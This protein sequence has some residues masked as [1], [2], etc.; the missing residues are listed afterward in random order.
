MPPALPATFLA[1]IGRG[2]GDLREGLASNE[3][4]VFMGWQDIRQRY[5]RTVLG[6]WWLAISTGLLVLVLGLL[7]S[8]IFQVEVRTFLPFFAVGYV[9]WTFLPAPST[10]RARASRSSRGSSSSGGFRSRRCSTGSACATRSASRTMRSSSPRSSSGRAPPG[11]AAYLLAVPGL[12]VFAVTVF[13]ALIPVAIFCTRFRDFPQ[14]V[15]NVLQVLFFATPIMWRPDVL[16]KYP[17]DRR[18]QPGRPSARHRQAAVAR[19][20]AGTGSRGSGRW[21][22]WSLRSSPPR[23]CWAGT[24]IASPTGSSGND[25][26]MTSIVAERVRVEYPILQSTNRS[27]KRRF[28][29]AA[30]GAASPAT[31]AITS[32]SPRS[33][34]SR[35]RSAAGERVALVGHNGSGKTT[36]LRSIAGVYEPV[37]RKPARGRARSRRCSTSRSAS[38]PKPP[39]VKTSTCEAS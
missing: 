10:R 14:I 7:W 5:R 19:G 34:T 26:G 29:S 15:G 38:I 39:G 36:L 33:T 3:L 11:R 16:R 18:I 25:A 8:E 37:E 4:W 22:C 30:T 17:V 35:S 31:R 28:V 13:L 21:R 1:S 27:L 2:A 24:G 9:L 20:G 12:V 32:S 23:I 6:P